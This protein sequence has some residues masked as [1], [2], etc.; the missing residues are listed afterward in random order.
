M[1]LCAC[2]YPLGVVAGTLDEFEQPATTPAMRQTQPL[3]PSRPD[4]LRNGEAELGYSAAP[5]EHF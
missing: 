4:C 3:P 5:S 1:A 2:L